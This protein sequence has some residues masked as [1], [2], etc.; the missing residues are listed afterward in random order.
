MNVLFFLGNG[1]DINLS[2]PTDYQSF[3]D[4]YLKEIS[5]SAIIADL[6]EYLSQERYK[7]WADLE[8]GLGQYTLRVKSVDEL[9]VVY[10]DLSDHLR[11]Y[12]Q[13]LLQ[14]F[15]PTASMR[16]AIAQGLSYPEAFLPYGVRRDLEAYI[17]ANQKRVDVV[18]F[19]YTDTFERLIS[20]ANGS[21]SFPKSFSN[22]TVLKSVRHIHMR[23]SDPDFIMGVNDDAQI[24]NQALLND[25]CRNLLVKPHINRQLQYLVD[26]ECLK[27]IARADLICLFGLSL[28]KTDLMWWDAIG[29]RMLSSNTRLVFFVHDKAERIRNSR[30]I[31]KM[32]ESRSLL[33]NRF[34]IEKVSDDLSRRII[35][36]CNTNI[37][38]PGKRV[39]V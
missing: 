18:S 23:L 11:A 16:E 10:N 3:Y 8:W 24:G 4:S 22:N 6:K 39:V 14:A 38:K 35:I 19:N 20:N 13:G 21:I 1:F 33:M 25:A 7:T 28:G 30:I 37:F 5:P 31:G 9:E 27:L 29:K 32:Q 12:L 36:G 34:G 17:G 26:E 15:L 2:L